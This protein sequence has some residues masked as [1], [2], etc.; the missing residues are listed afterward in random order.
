MAGCR[1]VTLNSRWQ[2]KNLAEH[3]LAYA[4]F[5]PVFEGKDNDN[6]HW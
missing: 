6:M 4:P 5:L 1:D 2:A 3:L